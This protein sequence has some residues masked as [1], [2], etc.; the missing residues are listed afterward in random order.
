MEHTHT[1]TTLSTRVS[2]A[3]SAAASVAKALLALCGAHGGSPAT[4]PPPQ[5]MAAPPRRVAVVGSGCSGL[6]A[7]YELSCRGAEVTVFESAGHVGGHACTL[8]VEGV[9]VDVGFMVCNRVTYPNMVRP[10][11]PCRAAHRLMWYMLPALCCPGLRRTPRRRVLLSAPAPDSTSALVSC[12]VPVAPS[13]RG[14]RRW[15]CRWK[16]PTCPSLSPAAPVPRCADPPPR[17]ATRHTTFPGCCSF[18]F[19]PATQPVCPA[20]AAAG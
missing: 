9:P 4:A 2:R 19:L 20:L 5:P 12:A 1:H 17:H 6:A 14:L 16:T 3:V 8:Q 7:A 11:L 18:L 15:A 13:W 10:L